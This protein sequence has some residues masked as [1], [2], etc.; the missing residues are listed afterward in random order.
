MAEFK[1][2]RWAGAIWM[3]DKE[4]SILRRPMGASEDRRWVGNRSLA[5]N[6]GTSALMP[7]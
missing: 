3:E 4:G 6:H 7:C 2:E 1:L 5:T